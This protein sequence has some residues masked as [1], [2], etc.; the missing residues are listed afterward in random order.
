[1][2]FDHVGL[3]VSDISKYFEEFLKP[4]CTVH[5]LSDIYTDHNQQS[6]VAFATTENQVRIELIEPL[7]G[8]GPVAEILK[9][10]KGGLHHLCFIADKFEADIRRFTTNGCLMI[11][12]PKPAVAF[13]GRRV[14]FFF[15]PTYEVIELVE[16]MGDSP[17]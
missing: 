12:P 17:L 10:K 7:E 5:A 1:M 13:N 16:E 6:K 9:R 4:V 3:V 11:S 14:V 15:T 2:K 8:K